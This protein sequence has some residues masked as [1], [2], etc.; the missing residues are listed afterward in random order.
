MFIVITVF[1]VLNMLTKVF[2]E[3]TSYIFRV[4]INMRVM[5][6]SEM[7]VATTKITW[8]Q[9]PED[10]HPR[11]N[12]RGNVKMSKRYFFTAILDKRSDEKK[13]NLA[14]TL[15]YKCV[16][17]GITLVSIFVVIKNYHI[18]VTDNCDVNIVIARR[19]IIINVCGNWVYSFIYNSFSVLSYLQCA[20]SFP[21]REISF[22]STEYYYNI[23]FFSFSELPSRPNR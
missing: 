8:V 18:K 17:M 5:N 23:D 22:M 6:S 20:F 9:N 14:P 10:I 15:V 3:Q 7:L 11:F 12:N 21:L 13:C 2:E 4:E 19:F 16:R 1:W